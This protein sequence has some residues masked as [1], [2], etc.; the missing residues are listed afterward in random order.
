M[1][2]VVALFFLNGSGHAAL[3]S[4][5]PELQPVLGLSGPRLEAG[6]QRVRGGRHCHHAGGTTDRRALPRPTGGSHR[7]GALGVQRLSGGRRGRG[8]SFVGWLIAAGALNA[9]VDLGQNV[10][11]VRLERSGMCMLARTR[12]NSLLSP[13]EGLPAVG[14]RRD[15]VQSA[16][17]RPIPAGVRFHSSGC[18][19]R[20]GGGPRLR[21]L[22]QP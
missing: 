10:L 6:T 5:L 7:R 19:G 4:R 13:L 8:A 22:A 14:H 15:R 12:P 18:R 17:H 16:H 21:G 3:A 9:L 2:S 1:W 11:V 20:A